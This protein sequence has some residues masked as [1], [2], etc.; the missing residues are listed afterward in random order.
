M[1]LSKPYE[2]IQE[3][4][5][6]YNITNN[7]IITFS[8]LKKELWLYNAKYWRKKLEEKQIL[9]KVEK[10]IYLIDTKNNNS[11]AELIHKYMKYKSLSYYL[12]WLSLFNSY[13]LTTQLSNQYIV[14]NS[15]INKYITILNNSVILKKINN[16]ELIWIT[17]LDSWKNSLD[18]ERLL[19]EII[20]RWNKYL[21]IEEIKLYFNN[22]DEKRLNKEKLIDYSKQ[23]WDIILRKVLAILEYKWMSINEYIKDIK[24]KSP[25]SLLRRNRKGKIIK[26]VNVI[27]DF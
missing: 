5:E 7:G 13:W 10:D 6:Y 16:I 15:N 9:I 2:K 3:I 27:L 8:I 12:W 18:Y 25:I 11:V 14:F 4:L 22:L 24:V 26:T 21:D 19:I 20:E 1:I 23:F 17:V